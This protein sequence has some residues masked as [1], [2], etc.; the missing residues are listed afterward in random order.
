MEKY[1]VGKKAQLSA[2]IIIALLIVIILV[3][4]LFRRDIFS[5]VG[6]EKDPLSQVR[7]CANSYA[8]EAVSILGNQGGV[9]EPTNYYVYE[10]NK[11]EYLCYSANYYEKCTMQRPFVSQ[12]IQKEIKAYITPKIKECMNNVKSSLERSGNVVNL[13]DVNVDVEL[14]PGHI[15][16]DVRSG[17]TVS[18][19]EVQSYKSIKVDKSSEL[20]ELAMISSSIMN[21]EARY[22][23]SETL[24]Y[25]LYYPQLKVEK[26]KQSDGTTIYILT[27]RDTNEKFMFA[28]RSVALPPG[29]TGA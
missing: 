5:I 22:G 10:G 8:G 20:Y 25:M 26:K 9:I 24:N 12:D 17:F 2:F 3:I 18:K 27:N 19:G 28:S 1:Q 6:G 14:V 16:M 7:E 11:V 4:F 15:V 29:L 23:G 13:G 21:W